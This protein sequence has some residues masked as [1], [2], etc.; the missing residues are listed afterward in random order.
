MEIEFNANWG[1][2]FTR[3]V[4]KVRYVKDANIKHHERENRNNSSTDLAA[5]FMQK[6]SRYL[7]ETMAKD[8]RP[9]PVSIEPV[10]I[11]GEKD[12]SVGRVARTSIVTMSCTR[13]TPKTI[14]PW[15]VSI[16]F[17]SESSFTTTI[18]ELMVRLNAI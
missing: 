4:R 15:R 16:S 3:R 7:L 10:I 6:G 18:V 11:D 5:I 12:P 2:S 17:L 1:L 14:S 8:T 9:M 13:S